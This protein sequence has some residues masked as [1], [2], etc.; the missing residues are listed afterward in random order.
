MTVV[1]TTAMGVADILA[2]EHQRELLAAAKQA[3]VSKSLNKDSGFGLRAAAGSAI[4]R[5]GG[6]VAGRDSSAALVG[7][8]ARA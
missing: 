8:P 3:R 2:A 1:M 7:H 5:A 6:W 4:I